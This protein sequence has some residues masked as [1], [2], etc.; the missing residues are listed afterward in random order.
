MTAVFR[1]VLFVLDG[2]L[3]DRLSAESSLV[4]ASLVPPVSLISELNSGK[5]S[6]KGDRCMEIKEHPLLNMNQAFTL[7]GVRH[8][9]TLALLLCIS[10]VP[11]KAS[12]LQETISPKTFADWCLNKDSLSAETKHTVDAILQE[13]KTQD[14]D[15]ADKL[16][17][18]RIELSLASKLITDLRPLSSLTHLTFLDLSNN[19]IADLRPLSTLTNLGLLSLENN[20]SLTDKTCPVQPES[21]CNFVP[22]QSE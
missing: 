9:A 3:K 6:G 21:I 15:Q 19:Q 8:L 18:N 5:G 4:I 14:C 10:S 22:L 1:T 2:W 11:A 7:S 16:L 20:P 13:A 12:P 17:S